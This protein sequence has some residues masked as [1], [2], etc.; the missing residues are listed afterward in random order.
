VTSSR[1]ARPFEAGAS[2]APL[3]HTEQPAA[4]A[5]KQ[6][7]SAVLVYANRTEPMQQLVIMTFL[8]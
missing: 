2:D 4:N 5:I 7:M 1:I 6:K 8:L 3:G